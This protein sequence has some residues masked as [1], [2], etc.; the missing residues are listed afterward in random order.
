MSFWGR[1]R[2]GFSACVLWCAFLAL[3]VGG[4]VLFVIGLI[5]AS[6]A[7]WVL[8][9]HHGSARQIGAKS[10][11]VF[12]MAAGLALALIVPLLRRRAASRS[13]TWRTGR[14]SEMKNESPVVK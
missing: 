9:H 1:F 11:E 4:A 6:R 5:I 13:G 14:R 10:A 8:V 2:H 12:V 7:C 3:Y